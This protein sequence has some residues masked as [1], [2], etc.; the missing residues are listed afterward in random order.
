M[1]IKLEEGLISSAL[2]NA[3]NRAIDSAMY[4]RDVH[5][6]I[7]ESVSNGIAADTIGQAVLSAV[8]NIDKSAIT[9][10]IAL[11]MQRCIVAGVAAVVEDAVVDIIAK[12]RSVY[13]DTEKQRIRAEL[14]KAKGE[15]K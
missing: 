13:T 4:S 5:N 1:E 6:A 7:V 10:A 3:F 11:E 14:L 2:E 9:Q 12:M 15:Q 8:N